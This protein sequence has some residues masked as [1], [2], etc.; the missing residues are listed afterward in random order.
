ME[1]TTT[2]LELTARTRLTVDLATASDLARQLRDAGVWPDAEGELDTSGA[3]SAPTASASPSTKAGLLLDDHPLWERHS[4]GEPHREPDEWDADDLDLA[5]AF[6]A[7]VRGKA[8]AF[9]DILIDHPARRLSAEEISGLAAPKTFK[10][11]YSVAG[12]IGG[13]KRPREQSDRRY[14]FYWWEG[15]PTTYAMKASV[16]KLF[17]AARQRVATR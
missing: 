7:G 14:P 3:A 11:H 1:T 10:N 6:Y 9:L 17:A 8:R 2:T 5:E 4:G 12:S 13:L 15:T 16:A